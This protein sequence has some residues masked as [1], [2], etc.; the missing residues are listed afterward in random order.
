MRLRQWH[1]VFALLAAHADGVHFADGLAVDEKHIARRVPIEPVGMP[2]FVQQ[3]EVRA[4][5]ETAGVV[6][7][8]VAAPVERVLHAAEVPQ[9]EGLEDVDLGADARVVVAARH[10]VA[11]QQPE[12]RPVVGAHML[13]E[14]QPRLHVAVGEAEEMV[15]GLVPLARADAGCVVAVGRIL[16]LR[17]LD[18]QFAVGDGD[19]ARVPAGRALAI[20]DRHVPLRLVDLRAVELIL[21]DEL[22]LRQIERR[23]GQRANGLEQLL[24]NR[25]Q[26]GLPDLVALGA[27][28]QPILGEEFEVLVPGGVHAGRAQVVDDDVLMLFGER[29]EPRV[30][31]LARTRLQRRLGVAAGRDGGDDD[32][33][34]GVE[35]REDLEHRL[36]VRNRV[37]GIAVGRQVVAADA[38]KDHL[39]LER[40]DVVG[41]AEQHAARGVAADAAVRDLV[42]REGVL[43]RAP[44]FGEGVADEHDGVEILLAVVEVLAADPLLPAERADGTVPRPERFVL[45]IGI[46]D[47]EILGTDDPALAQR[48]RRAVRR[49]DRVNVRAFLWQVREGIPAER[50]GVPLALVLK[51]LVAERDGDAE[52]LGSLCGE[53]HPQRVASEEEAAGRFRL[54]QQLGLAVVDRPARLAGERLGGEAKA[55]R[56]F[57]VSFGKRRGVERERAVRPRLQRRLG[58]VGESQIGGVVRDVDGRGPL[59]ILAFLENLGV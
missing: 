18:R 2:A 28:M 3:F 20:V 27:D 52:P 43:D 26:T 10:D 49:P 23:G 16:G 31:R 12:A 55:M 51:F 17:D 34:P 4:A 36:D 7:L 13:R 53:Q 46:R 54:R 30:D 1:A 8:A 29:L 11:G 15:L 5:R 37:L 58:A 6:L 24:E 42:L 14:F 48:H 47:V 19:V 35:R 41:Q 21:P 59:R 57:H 44:A 9:V 40:D 25:R 32:R 33:H 45:R 56:D 22:E 39:R 38:E 50:L